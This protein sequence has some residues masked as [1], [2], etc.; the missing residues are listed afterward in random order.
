MQFSVIQVTVQH[1]VVGMTYTLLIMPIRILIP[2]LSL[3]LLTLLQ[4]EFQTFIQ[5]WLE[6][7][8]S[9]PTKL[10]YFISLESFNPLD[11]HALKPFEIREICFL[12]PKK[13]I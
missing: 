1:L 8:T 3:A 6:P 13:G 2:L 12:L 4:V 11:F 5:S 10:R 7:C 9:H